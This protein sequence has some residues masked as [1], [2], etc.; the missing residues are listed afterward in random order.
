MS[1]L[2]DKLVKTLKHDLVYDLSL[3][4]TTFGV[5]VGTLGTAQLTLKA[6]GAAA[7]TAG[8]YVL[9]NLLPQAQEVV[10][11]VRATPGTVVSSPPNT[12]VKVTAVPAPPAA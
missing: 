4:A 7:I 1:N 2:T 5:Q 11:E 8:R 12:N 9:A 3:F 6:V 10:T